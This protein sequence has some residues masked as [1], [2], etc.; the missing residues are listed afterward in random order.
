MMTYQPQLSSISHYLNV[1]IMC[2][3]NVMLHEMGT[4]SKSVHVVERPPLT[5]LAELQLATSGAYMLNVFSLAANI[6]V[7]FYRESDWLSATHVMQKA[8]FQP[9]PSSSA[10]VSEVVTS[11]RGGARRP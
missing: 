10:P 8:H 2:V 3:T 4:T 1:N 7:G 9:I 5:Q 11:I 6:A